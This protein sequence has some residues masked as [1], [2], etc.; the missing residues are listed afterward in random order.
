MQYILQ[1]G[2]IAVLLIIGPPASGQVNES[3]PG[4]SVESLLLLA[5]EH[6]PEYASMLNE[7]TAADERIA[8][9]G[10]LPD[11]RLRVELMDITMGGAQSPTIL[12]N[13]VGSTRYTVMQDVPWFGKRD[14][15]RDIAALEADAAK[16]RALGTWAEL[17][18]RI[19]SAYA[20]FYYLDQSKRLTNEILDL[21]VR[22]EQ[23]AQSRYAGG[24]AVQQDV[25]R[26]QVEQSNMKNELIALE[27][28]QRMIQARLNMLASRPANAP[29]ALPEQLRPLPPAVR[30]EYN[31]LEQRVREHNPQV[32]SDEATLKAA[33]KN[34]ELVYKNR[35]PDFNVG[36]VP[37]QYHN[38]IKEWGLMVEINI[39]LQQSS[40]R[41]QEREAD[42]MIS[43]P[44]HLI[45]FC[46]T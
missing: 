44:P 42:A 37:V 12:P 18:S 16:S 23:I 41:S 20:Q 45:H 1:T 38:A 29:L 33:D 46:L 40:R 4:A 24:L 39:P 34:R 15:K 14:L 35:Y 5:K 11:P 6:N 3:V 13:Q 19:K 9:A 2:V 32:F 25:I 30:L 43:A 21:M 27:N 10:A 36:I 22:L 31:V 28:E 8:P 26:A 17:S 7:A